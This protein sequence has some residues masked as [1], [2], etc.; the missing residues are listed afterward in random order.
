[1]P[2]SSG[3]TVG[4]AIAADVHGKNHVRYGTFGSPDHRDDGC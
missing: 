3:V 4:G 2:G 1:V